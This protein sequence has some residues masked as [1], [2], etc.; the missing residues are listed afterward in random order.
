MEVVV[1]QYPVRIVNIVSAVAVCYV[2]AV[3]VLINRQVV[4][5]QNLGDFVLRL[6]LQVDI[7]LGGRDKLQHRRR[8]VFGRNLEEIAV[9]GI[10]HEILVVGCFRVIEIRA[11]PVRRK[12][13]DCL[14]DVRVIGG[15]QLAREL[16]VGRGRHEE[17]HNVRAVV[18]D[19]RDGMLVCAFAE[20]FI[21]NAL[22]AVAEQLDVLTRRIARAHFDRKVVQIVAELVVVL[23][24]YGL[25]VFHRNF[26]GHGHRRAADVVG[27]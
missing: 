19:V 13:V 8:A 23:Y 5:V 1:E 20:V 27:L 3:Y 10:G 6:T 15:G 17:L 22:G 25:G 11:P 18:I 9:P 16:F 26:D 2:I 7:G 21:Q 12:R 24:V 14:L 4:E